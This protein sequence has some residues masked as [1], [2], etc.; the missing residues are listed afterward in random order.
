MTPLQMAMVAAG[1][2]N[3]GVVMEPFVVQRIRGPDG[4]V[5]RR[6]KPKELGRAIERRGP[7]QE[8]TEMMTRAVV[9]A[10][11]APRRRSPASPSRARPA[12]P[13][14]A[15]RGRNTAWFICFAPADDPKVAVA[16]VVEAQSGTGGQTAA[17]IAKSVMQ[18]LLP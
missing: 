14:P 18:A 6:T 11:P 4:T 10:A 2:A 9:R 3:G 1:V 12:R 8:L 17:P 13:R 16:V 15:S 7:P 5:I